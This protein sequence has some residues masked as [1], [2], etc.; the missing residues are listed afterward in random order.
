MGLPRP[1]VWVLADNHHAY[2][3]EGRVIKGIK[4]QGAWR[5]NGFT[6]RFLLLQKSL[7]RVH[8]RLFEFCAKHGLPGRVQL[9]G[10][11]C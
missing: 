2:F 10:F 4:N 8:I 11:F 6:G 5:E 3:I 1:M 9:A 7:E